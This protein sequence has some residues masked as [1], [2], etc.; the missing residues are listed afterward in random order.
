MKKRRKHW[1]KKRI[2]KEGKQF[3]GDAKIEKGGKIK[4]IIF[5]MAQYNAQYK[6]AQKK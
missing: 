2:T 3:F 1:E 5:K 4:T 6:M